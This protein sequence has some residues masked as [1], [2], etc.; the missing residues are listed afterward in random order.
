M[1]GEIPRKLQGTTKK[2]SPHPSVLPGDISLSVSEIVCLRNQNILMRIE[3]F[4]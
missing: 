4:S 3:L 1:N 2:G